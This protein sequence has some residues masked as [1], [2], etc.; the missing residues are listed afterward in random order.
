MLS[1][2]Y[3]V[4]LTKVNQRAF[5]KALKEACREAMKQ[6]AREF[7]L[8]A[9]PRI[10][11]FT[12]FARGSLGNLEDIVGRI[13]ENGEGRLFFNRNQGGRTT[14]YYHRKERYYYYPGDGRKIERNTVS[15]RQFATPTGSILTVAEDSK[16][17]YFKF[18]VDIKYF[19]RLDKARW[20][21]F[22]TGEIAFAQ[23][24]KTQFDK[25]KPKVKDYLVESK[26]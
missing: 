7:L 24:L 6:A 16:V 19:T 12:G 4:S 8:A 15:G 21:A 5:T 11:V 3:Q 14:P 25:L 13:R 26:V 10:P 18:S 1:F 2:N 22:E 20:H 23:T 9:V 17:F